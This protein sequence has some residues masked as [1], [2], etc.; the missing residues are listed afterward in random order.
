LAESIA[1]P[2]AVFDNLP[3]RCHS[4]H[5][6]TIIGHVESGELRKAMDLYRAIE[7]GG[8]RSSSNRFSSAVELNEY[9]FA[10]LL[11]A[12]AKLKDAESGGRIH[13]EIA[14]RGFLHTNVVLGTAL[15][16][17]YSN[18]GMLEKAREALEKLPR[19]DAVAW[20]SLIS[21]YARHDRSDMALAA[22]DLMLRRG[23]S[24]SPATFACVLK[25]C[26]DV[27]D[28]GRGSE[29]HAEVARKGLLKTN[30][31]VGNALV[32]MYAK[33]G[34]LV[35]ARE[36]FDVLPCRDVVAWTSLISGYAQHEYGED[37]LD[38]FG[39]MQEQGIAPDVVTS[40]CVLKAC[41]SS[42]AVEKGAEIHAELARKGL[43]RSNAVVGSALVGMY[44]KCG[45]LSLASDVLEGLPDPSLDAWNALIAG[46]AQQN[47]E[48]EALECFERIAGQGLCP[49]DATVACSL[50]ACGSAGA[51]GGKGR[52]LLHADLENRLPRANQ[53]ACNALLDMY[54]KCGMLAK[55]EEVF[56]KLA[57]R[58]VVSW[59]T[60]I[61][62]YGRLR[63]SADA[64]NA[65]ERML[66]EGVDPNA[67][68]FVGVLDACRRA[69]L[70]ERGR[71]HFAEMSAKFGITPTIDHCTCMVHLLAHSGELIR[72]EEM[73]EQMS[74]PPDAVMLLGILSACL[75]WSNVELGRRAFEKLVRLNAKEAAAYDC[76]ESIYASLGMKAEAKKI[77]ARRK[78]SMA[79]I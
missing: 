51:A 75:K 49:D 31:F 67:S 34:S 13:A 3:R 68:T 23:M 38:C 65:F 27:G 39:Q 59:N 79:A 32:D 57:L 69:S 73:M 45:E 12:C 14:R 74:P 52:E 37:A 22:F 48:R 25:A 21:G 28:E 50:K 7:E 47:R 56:D 26:G 70:L 64:L 18:C 44:A 2:R 8:G 61:A 16:H 19:C 41:G 17:M 72:A 55:A 35:R 42:R 5:S 36:A 62:A 4:S 71:R 6:S 24:P 10:A 9:A 30:A 63:R 15:L 43:V 11:K 29:I 60:L 54:A 46:Y 20:T 78:K 33:C 66:V 40:V 77:R 76:M 53:I 58:D 1:E